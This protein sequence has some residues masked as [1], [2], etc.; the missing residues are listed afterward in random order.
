MCA[1]EDDLEIYAI[2]KLSFDREFDW[3][4]ANDLVKG[5]MTEKD[6]R[7]L[8]SDLETNLPA[9]GKDIQRITS[10][11]F[12]DFNAL[13]YQ[14]FNGHARLCGSCIILGNASLNRLKPSQHTNLLRNTLAKGRDL[15]DIINAP[16]NFTNQ[17]VYTQYEIDWANSPPPAQSQ[18]QN[19]NR[20]FSQPSAL[21][22]MAQN[23][24]NL[25]GCITIDLNN[26]WPWSLASSDN[27][28]RKNPC[29]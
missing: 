27:G 13:S 2:F 24:F 29:F 26:I 4:F 16:C 6:A 15:A 10:H 18:A 14:D 23:T 22:T 25:L 20:L 17:R 28:E 3:S 19:S 5:C 9:G 12:S 21:D 7:R 8:L 1:V 11:G